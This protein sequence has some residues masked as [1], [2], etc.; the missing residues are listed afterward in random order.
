MRKVT[1]AL[2][3]L[4]VFCIGTPAQAPAQQD[5]LY[6]A[7]AFGV[8]INCSLPARYGHPICRGRQP[9]SRSTGGPAPINLKSACANPDVR[10]DARGCPPTK[11]LHKKGTR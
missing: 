9:P 8:P 7:D 1:F 2:A 4:A 10:A 11:Q 5:A 6:G 3:V